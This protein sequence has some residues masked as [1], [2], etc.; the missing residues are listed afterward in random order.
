[1]EE[2]SLEKV[3]FD[4]PYWLR[5]NNILKIKTTGVDGRWQADY[6]QLPITVH[7]PWWQTTW[8]YTLYSIVLFSVIY[9]V[10]VYHFF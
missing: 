9:G 1:M 8:A 3:S 10:F 5:K 4:Q 2:F 7:P 6:R